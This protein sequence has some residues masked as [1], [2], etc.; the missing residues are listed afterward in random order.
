MVVRQPPLH[1]VW[2]TLPLAFGLWFVTFAV[3]AGNFWLKLCAS[4]AILALAG[5]KLSWKERGTLFAF[6][7]HHLWVG[8]SSALVLYGIFWTG[9]R[10][11][12]LIFPCRREILKHLHQ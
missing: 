6:K 11:S 9:K 7:P 10:V 1:S 5:L 12:S 3:P 8:V 4:A 2:W